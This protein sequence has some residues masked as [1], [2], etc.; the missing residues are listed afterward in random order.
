MGTR[1]DDDG[2]YG[3]LLQR[4]GYLGNCGLIP[5]HLYIFDCPVLSANSEQS[6]AEE[7]LSP[8]KI[9]LLYPL[10]LSHCFVSGLLGDL[11]FDEA[12]IPPLPMAL[13]G[14]QEH[15]DFKKLI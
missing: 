1:V 15:M 11:A 12:N 2:T 3:W 13:P 7:F 4:N 6:H 14:M 8:P 9:R 5:V 10:L